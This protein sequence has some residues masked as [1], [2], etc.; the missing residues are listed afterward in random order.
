M[1]RPVAMKSNLHSVLFETG[2]DP[3]LG[4]QRLQGRRAGRHPALSRVPAH[5]AADAP[6]GRY[7]L[8]QT[9]PGPTAPELGRR[10]LPS[11]PGV[12]LETIFQT[13]QSP[14][15]EREPKPGVGERRR[16]RPARTSDEPTIRPAITMPTARVLLARVSWRTRL[17]EVLEVEPDGQLAALDRFER[18]A[19]HVGQERRDPLEV[20]GRPDRLGQEPPGV[21]AAQGQRRG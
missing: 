18:L 12:S 4:R 7:S 13:S 14:S 16:T 17:L 11:V 2:L 19:Q 20:L 21:V 15:T 10:A 5:R 6:A 8:P 3:P 1:D 9:F